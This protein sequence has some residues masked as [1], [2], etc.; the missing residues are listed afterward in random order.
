MTRL[1]E[2]TGSLDAVKDRTDEE[3]LTA[4]RTLAPTKPAGEEVDE[5]R[6]DG[7]HVGL[8]GEVARAARPKSP[9]PGRR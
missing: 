6:H 9:L 5:C 8:W 1:N 7:K 2:E 4:W 3:P